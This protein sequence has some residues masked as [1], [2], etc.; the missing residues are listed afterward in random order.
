MTAPMLCAA[1]GEAMDDSAMDVLR[2]KGCS[3]SALWEL[4]RNPPAAAYTSVTYLTERSG[5]LQDRPLPH[6][7]FFGREEELFNLK[8]MAVQGRKFLIS[9]V[10]GIG[11]TELLRQLL[12]SCEEDQSID[13]IAIVPY[14][15]GLVESFGKAFPDFR[16]QEAEESFHHIRYQLEQKA[17]EGKRIVLL[18]DNMN[19]S[20]E[21]DPALSRLASLFCAVLISSRRPGFGRLTPISFSPQNRRCAI[22]SL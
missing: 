22:I 20:L 18:I 17:A 3:I 19:R 9:G 14:A 5:I 13:C 8:E 21:D 2:A 10:G 7:R 11:K 12:Q 15:A 4:K 16:L 1:V 6:Q